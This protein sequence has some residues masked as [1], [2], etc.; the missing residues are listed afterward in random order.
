[1]SFMRPL[2]AVLALAA[3]GDHSGTPVEVRVDP[4]PTAIIFQDAEGRALS[5]TV[6]AQPPDGPWLYEAPSSTATVT[7]GWLDQAPSGGAY[8]TLSTLRGLDEG[9]SV[10]LRRWPSDRPLGDSGG[11]PTM[12]LSFEPHPAGVE[13][14]IST[15]CQRLSEV[16]ATEVTLSFPPGCHPD[17]TFDLLVIA[18]TGG[19]GLAGIERRA[20]PIVDG[21][22]VNVNAWTEG[23]SLVMTA[24]NLPPEMDLVA[25]SHATVLGDHELA[26]TE[27]RYQQASQ[28]AR[29]VP[30]LR[31]GDGAVRVAIAVRSVPDNG[32]TM[33]ASVSEDHA[34]AWEV[35]F[36]NPLP[37]RVDAAVFTPTEISWNRSSA[38]PSDVRM[39]Y[40]NDETRT[41]AWTVI[42]PDDGG[43]RSPLPTLDASFDAIVGPGFT[44]GGVSLTDVLQLDGYEAIKPVADQLADL[45][46]FSRS[47]GYRD[48][49]PLDVVTTFASTD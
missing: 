39:L 35:D 24:A 17:G 12:T 22:T 34:D 44:V 29:T 13:Y 16:Q 10:L 42:E 6:L 11:G 5:Y 48:V 4:G 1:M 2:L 37:A 40:A 30:S 47:E 15:G 36:A 8:R 19:G 33:Y 20:Q 26:E 27:L 49:A 21:G 41:S 43:T 7:A 25:F 45:G 23:A 3:C 18:R 46:A 28:P 14:E 38:T 9:D 31:M 32:G